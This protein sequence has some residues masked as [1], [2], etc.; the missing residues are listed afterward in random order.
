MRF[1]V[2]EQ[3]PVSLETW[4]KEQGHDAKRMTILENGTRISDS[5][6]AAISMREKSIVI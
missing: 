2:D 1:I 3:L 6:I 4:L 5:E